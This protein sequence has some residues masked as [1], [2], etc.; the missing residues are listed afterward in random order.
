MLMRSD[1]I[2]DLRAL[3]LAGRGVAVVE[4]AAVLALAV[5][6]RPLV[7]NAVST[8][9]GCEKWCILSEC[10]QPVPRITLMLLTPLVPVPPLL[11]WWCVL[12]RHRK[13][14]RG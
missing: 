13:V 12:C 7:C 14:C 11:R 5:L 10:D 1:D 8:V 4:P 3:G 2:G 9:S 6:A